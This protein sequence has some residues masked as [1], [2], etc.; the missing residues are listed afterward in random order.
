MV[1]GP[2]TAVPSAPVL[3]PSTVAPLIGAPVAALV[4][5]TVAVVPGFAVVGPVSASSGPRPSVYANRTR[6]P[7]EIGSPHAPTLA[8]ASFLYSARKLPLPGSNAVFCPATSL[9]VAPNWSDHVPLMLNGV[10]SDAATSAAPR[11]GTGDGLEPV[12]VPSH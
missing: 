3:F 1:N 11:V 7:P 6:S 2:T 8:N 10:D 12:V 5:F 9:I 4:T